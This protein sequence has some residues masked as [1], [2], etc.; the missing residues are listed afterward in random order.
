MM[1]YCI[2]AW[3]CHSVPCKYV[4]LLCVN[5]KILKSNKF[6]NLDEFNKLPENLIYQNW[7]KIKQKTWV[8]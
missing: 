8:I 6:E 3:D 1:T 7:L 2:H 5:L 4:Q